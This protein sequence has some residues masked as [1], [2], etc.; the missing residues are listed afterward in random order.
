MTNRL[1][2][3]KPLRLL[4]LFALSCLVLHSLSAR[5]IKLPLVDPPTFLDQAPADTTVSCPSD[6][7]VPL[8][9]R[10]MD[11]NDATFMPSKNISAVDEPSVMSI[12]PCSGGVIIRRW[13]ATDIDN[14][15]DTVTQ[16]I[17]ILPDGAS[18]VPLIPE[19]RDTFICGNMGFVDYPTWFNTVSLT[20]ATNLED[21]TGSPTNIT[22]NAPVSFDDYCGSV[23]VTFTIFD[24]CGNDTTWTATY[25]VIDNTPPMLVG[26]P[27]NQEVSN[28]T[29]VINDTLS[30]TDGIPPVPMVTATDNCTPNLVPSFSEASGQTMDGSC[31]QFNYVILRNW[32]VSDSC[33]NATNAI[34]R[35]VVIDDEAPD[36]EDPIDL[37]GANAISCSDDINDFSI[38]GFIANASDNCST[39]LDTSYFDSI[40]DSLC[41]NGYTIQRLW[42]VK[43]V[44]GNT[45]NKVQFIEVVDDELPTFIAPRDTT[46]NCDQSTASVVTGSPA[47]VADNC[48]MSPTIESED[49]IE[50]GACPNTYTIRRTWRVTDACGNV[51]EKLQIINVIDTIAPA[52]TSQAQD[53]ELV[54]DND[55][56]LTTAFNDWISSRAGAIA[57]DN[58][59]DEGIL[60]W[61]V[62]E[63]G[64]NN[65]ATLPPPICP[66]PDSVIRLLTVDFIVED[67][68]GNRDTSTATFKVIDDLPP[69]LSNCPQDTAIATNPGDCEAIFV[70]A[71]PVIEEEC[72][73]SFDSEDIAVSA[74]IVSNAQPG[75]EGDVPA[76]TIILQFNVATPP[77]VNAAGNATLMIE[78]TNADAEEPTEFFR[79]IG[80]DG[81][82]LGQTAATNAQCGASITTL[83]LSP[84]QINSWAVDGIVVIQLVPN[85]PTDQAGR[86][87]VN[88]ICN[89]VGMVNGRL[90]FQTKR[91]TNL[92]YEYSINGGARVASP[93]VP[94]TETLSP[95]N[96][97]ITYYVTDC[98]GGVDSCSYT[99]IVE[100]RE[101]PELICPDDITVTLE[102]GECTYPIT[103]PLPIG[104]T[105][106]CGVGP[107]YQLTLPANLADAYLT[108]TFDPNLNDYLADSKVI[109]F[110][111]VAANAT[112]DAT[113]T[114]DLLGDFNSNG[115]FF[116]VIGDD[117]STIGTTTNGVA[118]CNTPGQQIFIVPA[119]TFNDWAADGTIEITLQPNNINVP[120]GV[121]GDG[122]NPCNPAIVSFNGDTDSTSFVLLTLTYNQLTPAFY[123]KGATEVPLTQMTP[124]L[125]TPTIDFNLGET[126]VFYI[127]TDN[128][129]NADTCSFLITVEDNELP[130]ARCQPTTIFIN[131]SGLDIKTLPAMV[132][133]AGSSDNCSIDTMFLTPN[134]F[135]CTQA[136]TNATVTLTVIDFA[137]NTAT[138]QALVRIEAEE[139]QPTANS[140]LCGGDTL[141]L[142]ANPP[143]A[144]GGIIYTY[145]WTGPNGFFSTQRNPTIPRVTAI[146]AGTYTVEVTGLTGCT[147]VGSVQVAIEDLPLTPAVLAKSNV[148][149]NEDIVLNSSVVPPGANV[150]Y[151]WY[152]GT[153]PNGVLIGTTSVPSFTIAQPHA[154]GTNNYYITIEADGCLSAPSASTQVT[155][156][157][158]PTAAVNDAEI[159]VCESESITLG[160]LVSG[161]GITYQ[162]SGPNNYS[163]TNQSPPVIS[164]ATTADAGVYQ[165]IVLRNGCPSTPAFTVVNVRR[166]PATPQVT[167]NAPVCEGSNVVLSTTT[168]GATVYHWVAPN[169]QE[170]LTNTNTFTINTIT[171]SQE[172]QWRLYVTQS[173]CNSDLSAPLNV[174]VNTV[175]AA[176]ASANPPQVCEG[177]IL[178]L[179]ASPM[180][181]NATYR[182]T[183]PN[184]YMAATPNPTI[185][186][187]TP[188]QEGTYE[189]T[190][191]TL[192]GCSNKASVTVDVQ[193]GVRIT[194]VSNDGQECLTGPIDITLRA[195]VLPLN[196][197]TYRFIWTGPNNFSSSDSI[198]VIPNATDANNGNY[199]L[200][201][202]NGEG[203]ASQPATTIV[204]VALP[205]ATPAVPTISPSTPAP[206]C[207]GKPVSLVATAYNGNN[208]IYNWK[209]PKG[210]ISTQTPVLILAN[211]TM[212]DNGLYTVTVIVDGCSSKESGAIG[213]NINP[214]PQI[215]ATSNSPVCSGDA[216]RL[217]ANVIAGASY[218]WQGP[219]GFSSSVAN[220][221]IPTSNPTLNAGFYRVSAVVNGCIS[222]LDSVQVIVNS[223][224]SAPS[225]SNSGPVCIS[226][227]NA[228]LRLSVLAGSAVPNATYT[229]FNQSGNVVGVTQNLNFDLVDFEGFANGSYL[230]TV[231]A[232]VNGCPSGLSAPTTVVMNTIPQEEAS[233]GT[234]KT[235]CE[236]DPV[237]FEALTP[238]IG[239]GL[240]SLVSGDTTGLQIVNPASASSMVTGLRGDSVYL[241]QWTL[242]NGACA[243][244]DRDTVQFSV[245]PIEIP[246]A[247]EDTVVCV[248][249]QV[250]LNA[251]LPDSGEGRWSQP[252]AQQT[253]GVVIVNPENPNTLITGLE[254]GNLYEFTWTIVSGCGGL[255]DKVSI[256][257]SDTEPNAGD[258]AIA[259]NEDM[260]FRLNAIRPADG[261]IG[262]WTS[263]NEGLVFSSATDPKATVS[264]LSI[265]ENLLFWTIDD[266]LCGEFSRDS[267][268]INYKMNPLA[269]D[270]QVIVPFGVDKEFDVLEND[271]VPAGTITAIL[272]PP[273]KGSVEERG[274]GQ[275]TYKPGINFVGTDQMTYEICS[276][277]CECSIAT[278]IFNV[279]DNAQCDIPSIITP[280]G[281]GINDNFVIPCFI[282]DTNYPNNQVLIYNRWGDEVYRSPMPYKNN[283]DGTFNG[284]D[285]PPGTYFYVVN[286]GDGSEAKTGFVMIQR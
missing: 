210:L 265:G 98:T 14:M 197:G 264:N 8:T 104:A 213:I 63:S 102:P 279:G 79:I 229:W 161:P 286:F 108:Y 222:N 172:G 53:L 270:D 61:F 112:S 96:N 54:C 16:V 162:W 45:N 176:V 271:Q 17:T 148:C 84:A 231:N 195:T 200:V 73:A 192:E 138:C 247:G 36:F 15:S 22:N 245:I 182:W 80:E 117:G 203:C 48:D 267:V 19:V 130:V 214:A 69:M 284:E 274:N 52:F 178:Q 275:F 120:P 100:D 269:N 21:C 87:A 1:I 109:T 233:A 152:R 193:R 4:L 92:V 232:T 268:I 150:V 89:P 196:D 74:P 159:T 251:Q 209:T 139:P 57:S 56:D 66:A 44:C 43:D 254:S 153:A 184:N 49:V 151:R 105:D 256:L 133:D 121:M 204:D 224:P 23:A 175:P 20:L 94:V 68:C 111:N 266:A 26:L 154:P 208:V 145:R 160:T 143:A 9:L 128:I 41:P 135:N 272:T 169:L 198:A 230:F 283:W 113:F 246:F 42:V 179:F 46:I 76:N 10:A 234:D 278:V 163:S 250:I 188:N 34:W 223:R 33:G 97:L 47:L 122:I 65:P 101:A 201:V 50:A 171:E 157:S 75:Q 40:V 174:V 24:D 55:F 228:A 134:T 255:F 13:I 88:A 190:I 110:N 194:A 103:L 236:A 181:S 59:S 35:I 185:S 114:L 212:M 27:S 238:S 25:T 281:D 166:K 170:F 58:C 93:I 39:T 123:A 249:D 99:V 202:T 32:T 221:V 187:V 205:P 38:T 81:S 273:T 220:P 156:N 116:T 118:N 285:L 149:V 177:N 167:S 191:T 180:L 64:T 5:K 262:R 164:A 215:F 30:C 141:F 244:Y 95:G 106:N 83:T 132:I 7:P 207:E 147:S 199:Q 240:W 31:A 242:S 90:Q 142:F 77:P 131:P 12:D 225:A 126:E 257:T 115:A 239:G 67:E 173:G 91:F 18:P 280:N 86:F 119:E 78:L 129:G 29:I 211:P 282:K 124:P 136:E 241:F 165:L 85:I 237:R 260:S 183:G 263:P 259:C 186:N 71:P 144:Q 253:L 258:N 125:V 37:T 2:Y 277:G 62:F 82:V 107:A 235:I 226:N 217:E 11:D 276:E 146:N 206:F 127:I 216:I 140:G 261:S 252:E 137:G 28:G 3:T 243:N 72:A 158:I 51:V 168:T 227:A 6:V 218:A 219:A 70:L 248:T 189:V 155:A 60:T